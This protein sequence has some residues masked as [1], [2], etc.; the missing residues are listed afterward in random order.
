[1]ETASCANNFRAGCP[2]SLW[3]HSQASEG[4]SLELILLLEYEITYLLILIITLLTPAENGSFF[5]L[6]YQKEH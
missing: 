5:S 6:A 3:P 4:K 1:M 2:L